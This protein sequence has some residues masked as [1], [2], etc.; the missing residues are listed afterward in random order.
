MLLQ[1]A[2]LTPVGPDNLAALKFPSAVRIHSISIFP[3]NHQP[4]ALS[5]EI[6]R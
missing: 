5:P 2:T 1:W 6:V 4:F 3:S